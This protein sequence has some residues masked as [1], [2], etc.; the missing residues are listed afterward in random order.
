[1]FIV[2]KGEMSTVNIWVGVEAVLLYNTRWQLSL[3]PTAWNLCTMFVVLQAKAFVSIVKRIGVIH[4][5]TGI[6]QSR[7]RK[8]VLS[9]GCICQIICI[10][11][12]AGWEMHVASQLLNKA[13]QQSIGKIN[14]ESCRN[15]RMAEPG[16]DMWWSSCPNSLPKGIGQIE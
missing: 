14:L 15:H 7:L 12:L 9:S 8:Y 13:G 4:T 2:N 1:M 3:T 11:C 6:Y 10:G 5:A 16:R